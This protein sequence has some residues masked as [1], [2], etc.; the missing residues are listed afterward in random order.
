MSARGSAG[1]H[2]YQEG[3]TADPACIEPPVDIADDADGVVRRRGLSH[4]PVT[5]VEKKH[6]SRP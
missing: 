1:R 3:V 4:R 6:T 2:I 5:V